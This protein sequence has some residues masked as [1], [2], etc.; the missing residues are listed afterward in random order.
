M[1]ILSAFLLSLAINID[2]LKFSFSSNTVKSPFFK[3]KILF[4][5]LFTSLITFAAMCLGKIIDIYFTQSLS[6]I[7]GAVLLG[8]IGVYYVIEHIRKEKDKAGYD[9]SFYVKDFEE[10]KNIIELEN[11]SADCTSLK[12][13]T[14]IAFAL[15]LNNIWPCIAGS[16][17]NISISLTVLLNFI[18]CILFFIMSRF[19]TNKTLINFIKSNYYLITSIFLII[20]SIFECL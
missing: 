19:I 5:S 14:N 20:L 9:T 3:F 7:F 11:Y 1:N 17:T 16:I 15:S 4:T 12:Q 10:H 13:I 18:I 8:F 6:N 2:I